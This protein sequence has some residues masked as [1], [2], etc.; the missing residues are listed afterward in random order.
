MLKIT[1]A[2][3]EYY[4]FKFVNEQIRVKEGIT[5]EEYLFRELGEIY[6][7]GE[8]GEVYAT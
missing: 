6:L 3:L 5:F 7:I 1:N 4:G 8:L 2:H